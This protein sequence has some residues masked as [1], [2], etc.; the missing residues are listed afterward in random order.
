MVNKKGYF[1][2]IELILTVILISI[3]MFYFPQ[4]SRTHTNYE[5]L[6]NMKNIG[7]SALHNLDSQGIFNQNFNINISNSD[8][9]TLSQHIESSI[10]TVNVNKIEYLISNSDYSSIYCLDRNGNSTSC[11]EVSKKSREIVATTLYTYGKK[12]EPVTIKLY[13]GRDLI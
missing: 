7:Y 3:A 10:N 4:T 8:F 6:E 9:N 11:G 5:E 2:L 12:S 13:L 1:Y